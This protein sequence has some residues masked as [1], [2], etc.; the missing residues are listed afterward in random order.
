M[1]CRFSV[2][3]LLTIAVLGLGCNR[4]AEEARSQMEDTGAQM[5]KMVKLETSMGDIIIELNEEAAPVTVKNFL[6]YVREGFYN[7]TIF[8]RVINNF[9]I[10][11]GGFTEQMVRKPT[12]PPIVNEASNGLKTVRGSIAMARTND[13]NSATSQFFI[14]HKDNDALNYVK[15]GSPGYAVFDMIADGMDVVDEIA[16]VKTTVRMGMRDVPTESVV[17]KS[18]RVISGQ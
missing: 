4:K 8:H 18:A 1:T 14:N 13:P 17:I 9:M 15:D 7:G 16:G 11:G 10:Q 6:M 12:K 5:K 3:A 2:C